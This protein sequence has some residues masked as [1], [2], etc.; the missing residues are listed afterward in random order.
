MWKKFTIMKAHTLRPQQ[1]VTQQVKQAPGEGS[2]SYWFAPDIPWF[3]SFKDLCPNSPK[4]HFG[5]HPVIMEQ[6]KNALIPFQSN[7]GKYSPKP[8]TFSYP[9]FDFSTLYSKASKQLRHQILQ[10]TTK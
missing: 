9:A 10:P 1:H 6:P 4:N 8:C 7:C 3:L 2:N 5:K